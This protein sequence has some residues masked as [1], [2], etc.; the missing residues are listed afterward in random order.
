MSTALERNGAVRG[1]P[2]LAYDLVTVLQNKLQAID[3][4]EKYKDDARQVEH[5]HALKVFT[6]IQQ[7]DQDAVR[8]LQ[9]MVAHE[10]VSGLEDQ[11][12]AD[13]ETAEKIWGSPVSARQHDD[14]VVEE[15]S[16]ASFP[17]SDPPAYT[18][19]QHRTPS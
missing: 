13:R 3:A 7:S 17:A 8:R 11:G 14:E 16:D 2:N 4:L 12:I 9:A 15:A 10:L 19:G 1:L 6:E 18:K 5:H